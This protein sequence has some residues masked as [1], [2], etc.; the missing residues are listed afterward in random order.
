LD[1][2]ISASTIRHNTPSGTNR[3]A[4]TINLT[5]RMDSN[6]NH[7]QD[8]NSLTDSNYIQSKSN[9]LSA[10]LK[11]NNTI[12]PSVVTDNQNMKNSKNP[13]LTTREID[14][15]STPNKNSSGKKFDR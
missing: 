2:E 11:D 14:E 3:T 5:S 4:E 13:K 8:N 6:H 1:R 9:T 7:F 10:N 12:K 15:N